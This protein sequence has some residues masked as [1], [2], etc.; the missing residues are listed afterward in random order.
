MIIPPTWNLP[1]AIRVRLG[2]STYGRQR[3]IVEEGHLLLVLHKPPG[4]DDRGREG[5][6]F[7]RSPAG[8]WQCNRGGPGS[9]GLK[10]HVQ[11]YVDIE[12]KLTQDYEAASTNGELFDLQETLTPLVRASRGMHNAMQAAREA[13]KQDAFII[14]VR[15]LAYEVERNLDLLFEDVRNAIQQATAREAEVQA[16]ASKEALTASHRLNIL[17]ALFLPLTAITSLFGM[18]FTRGIDEHIPIMFWLV[19]AGGVTLGFVIKNWVTAKPKPPAVTR[20]Q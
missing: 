2:Q 4:P 15:D 19:F 1:E 10:R 11:S 14:E 3:A 13:I 16:R 6:L 17:A 8:E 7:W 12:G 5:V 9:G 18:N 20:K